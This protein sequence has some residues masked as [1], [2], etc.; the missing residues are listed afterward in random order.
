MVLRD[1]VGGRQHGH[2]STLRIQVEQ[3]IHDVVHHL[4]IVAGAGDSRVERVDIGEHGDVEHR[5][6]PD[7]GSRSPEGGSP[8]TVYQPHNDGKRE[9]VSTDA[10]YWSHLLSSSSGGRRK[11]EAG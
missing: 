8:G 2:D 5:Q 4:T 6:A 11:A 3:L 1:L 7:G 10:R 9:P